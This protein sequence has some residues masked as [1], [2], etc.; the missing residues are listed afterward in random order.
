MKPLPTLIF[1]VLSALPSIA[2]AFSDSPLEPLPPTSVGVFTESL[3]DFYPHYIRVPLVLLVNPSLLPPKIFEDDIYLSY[4]PRPPEKV[5]A[6]RRENGTIC[7]RVSSSGERRDVPNHYCDYCPLYTESM[8]AIVESLKPHELRQKQQATVASPATALSGALSWLQDTHQRNGLKE[9][10]RYIVNA[11]NSQGASLVELEDGVI[12][13]INATLA[14]RRDV[15][16]NELRLAHQRDREQMFS[17]INRTWPA[18][19]LKGIDAAEYWTRLDFWRTIQMQYLMVKEM[20][21]ADINAAFKTMYG[22]QPDVSIIDNDDLWAKLEAVKFSLTSH[23]QYLCFFGDSVREA[24]ASATVAAS[25]CRSVDRQP[26][27]ILVS[28]LCGSNL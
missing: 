15:A 28:L 7:Y 17:R 21:D 11:V 26:T 14:L 18:D 10:E 5:V 19:E 23:L 9:K 2:I 22:G 25:G 27:R 3:G 12:A 6:D 16:V 13:V 8:S 1:T 4:C 24:F 20:Y